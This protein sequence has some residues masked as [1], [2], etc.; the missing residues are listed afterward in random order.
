MDDNLI[1]LEIKEEIEE[2]LSFLNSK[3]REL[4]TRYYL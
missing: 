2:I 3:D 1:Q 4:F